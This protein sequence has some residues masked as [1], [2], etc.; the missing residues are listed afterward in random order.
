MYM[1]RTLTRIVDSQLDQRE[2][3]DMYGAS[4]M[5]GLERKMST[6]SKSSYAGSKS[7]SDWNSKK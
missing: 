2:E 5:S 3:V 7:T 4:H 6:S 1:S